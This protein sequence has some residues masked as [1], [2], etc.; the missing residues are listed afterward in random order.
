MPTFKK[1]N[2]EG[3]TSKREDGLIF[4]DAQP[5]FFIRTYKSGAP[6]VFGVKYTCG[7]KQR[8]MN[9]GVA[10]PETLATMRELAETTRAKAKLGQDTLGEQQAARAKVASAVTLGRL[11]PRY[12]KD[13]GG[14][15]RAR[16]LDY[17]TRYM[18]LHWKPLH[19][20]AVDAIKRGDVV[21]VIDDIAEK[22][23]TVAADRARTALSTFFG[24]CIDR[25]YVENTPCLNIR[26]RTPDG[27][28]DRVLS[29]TE[30]V[31]VWNECEPDDFG[32]ITRLLIL[33]GCRKREIGELMWSEVD[34]EARQVVLPPARVK[35]KHGFVLPLSE[36]AVE[37]LR[38][39]PAVVDRNGRVFGSF[40]W[41]RYKE[42]LDERLPADMPEWVLHDLRRSFV[43]TMAENGI[44]PPHIIEAC[45]NH[46]SGHKAGVAGIYNRAT[47]L[48]EKTAAFAAWGRFVDGLLAGRRPQKVVPIQQVA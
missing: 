16:S 18:Q 12:L 38:K 26:D 5:G 46:I 14:H 44:A 37:I 17:A 35:N 32:R 29:T 30:L 23:G 4:D 39:C 31:N 11:L 8:R 2:V 42:E 25:G 28:R 34:F 40:S 45:V 9:L 27:K 24:W 3:F 10:T 48:A 7:G 1:D 21:G 43:T 19:G 33:T 36:Q 15:L 6:A 22:R 47:Y 13:R 41:S 20:M